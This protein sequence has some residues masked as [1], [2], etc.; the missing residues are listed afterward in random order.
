M[1]YQSKI[2]RSSGSRSRL[3]SGGVASI[4]LNQRM[5]FSREQVRKGSVAGDWKAVGKDMKRACR[6]VKNELES[7]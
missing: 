3:M 1:T 5:S 6:I 2:S 4:D 7:A